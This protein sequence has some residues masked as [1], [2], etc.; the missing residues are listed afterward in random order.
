MPAE[1]KTIGG[2][3]QISLGKEHAG[4]TVIVEEVERGVWMVRTAQVIPDNERWLHTTEARVSL[5]RALEISDST[6]RS[7][8]DLI[9]LTRRMKRVRNAE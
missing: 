6:K 8:S 2:S 7:E 4:R 9:A 5:D 1:I 3:G